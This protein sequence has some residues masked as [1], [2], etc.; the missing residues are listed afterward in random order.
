MITLKDR[1]GNKIDGSVGYARGRILSD[2]TDE[3]RRYSHGL[4]LIQERAS[5]YGLESIAV[6]TGNLRSLP[7]RGEDIELAEEWIGSAIFH[8]QL[9]V[10]AR[11]HLSANS[12][13]G[14]AVFNR[15]SAGIIATILALCSSGVPIISV[16]PRGSSHASIRRGALLAQCPLVEI[17]SE[18]QLELALDQ[19]AGSPVFITGVTSELDVMSATMFAN[20]IELAHQEKRL[21]FV[22]D[23]YGAR[24]RTIIFN[25]LPARKLGA[26]IVITN[27]DKA[28]LNGPRAGILVGE[29]DLIQSIIAKGM[30]LGMEA[31]APIALGVLRSLQSF[32]PE[33]LLQEVGLGRELYRGL[34]ERIGNKY[35]AQATIGPIIRE[36][37]ILAVA[38]KRA[39]TADHPLIVPA[40]AA[41]AFGMLLLKNHGILTVNVSGMPGARVSIRLKPTPEQ[42]EKVGGIPAV[43]EAVDDTINELAK[44]INKPGTI[45]GLITGNESF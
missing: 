33:N 45:R 22:D 37:D 27:N 38:L 5:L 23:A 28:G 13:D 24:V 1:F 6:F 29:K 18:E 44:I 43:I 40:E 9:I 36:D 2:P 11:E 12:D 17:N 20:C 3:S 8:P 31:R 19:F 30:E 7:I 25:Q 26:D 21:V 4:R 10:C 39:G 42:I 14:V 16:V 15:T 34:A 41:A 35:V 32:S